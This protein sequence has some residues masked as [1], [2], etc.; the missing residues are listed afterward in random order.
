MNFTSVPSGSLP[1]WHKPHFVQS[2]GPHNEI[3]GV[4]TSWRSR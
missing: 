4:W 1:D 3:L 2:D